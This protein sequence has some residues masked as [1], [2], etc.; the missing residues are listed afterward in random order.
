M[1]RK[2]FGLT[3]PLAGVGLALASVALSPASKASSAQIDL[4]ANSKVS[5]ADVGLPA[6]PGASP[7]KDKDKDDD[8]ADLGLILGD[9]HFRLKVATFVAT[10]TPGHLLD[11]YRKPLSQFG[12]VLECDHGKPVGS[13]SA[14]H[15]GLTCSDSKGD[16]INS[17]EHQLR[18]GTPHKFRIVAIQRPDSETSKALPKDVTRFSLIYL[19]IPKDKDKS[20]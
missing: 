6:Y 13:V 15:S 2:I 9:F 17:D 5:A 3:I 18:A 19:E 11:F 16:S 14:T 7:Y 12:E 4:H 1:T 20:Q 10:D 8:S